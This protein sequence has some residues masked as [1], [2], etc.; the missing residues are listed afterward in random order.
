MVE[1]PAKAK[2]GQYRIMEQLGQGATAKVFL[3]LDPN[4]KA[5]AIKVMNRDD[6]EMV[7]SE[8]EAL[9]N[10]NHPNI[11][12]MVEYKTDGYFEKGSKKTDISYI[13]L[14]LADG[15]ELIDYVMTNGAFEEKMSRFFFSQ[16][17]DTL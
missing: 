6:V 10:L 4:D 5:Y 11:V 17:I 3:G 9:D 12:N 16:I 14:E 7:K 2:I 13:V 8:L 1:A 15:G